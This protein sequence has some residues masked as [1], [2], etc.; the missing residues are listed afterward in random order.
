MC[1]VEW[2]LYDS[3]SYIPMFSTCDLDKVVKR[4]VSTSS[5]IYDISDDDIMKLLKKLP[6]EYL[7]HYSRWLAITTA[8]KNMDKFDIWNKWSKQSNR[9]D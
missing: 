8:M 9:Y 1:L 4:C 6:S 5:Y 7:N 3:K 2:L